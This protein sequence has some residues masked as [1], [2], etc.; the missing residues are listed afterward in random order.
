MPAR[1]KGGC[2]RVCAPPLTRVSGTVV[3]P[4]VRSVPHRPQP[5]VPAG[6]RAVARARLSLTSDP[7]M[8]DA[9]LAPGRRNASAKRRMAMRAIRDDHAVE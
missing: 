5:L 9:T 2:Q 7:N 6:N 8:R 1:R 4:Q 3:S